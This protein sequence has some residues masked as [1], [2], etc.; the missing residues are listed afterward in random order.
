M[1]IREYGWR[2]CLLYTVQH[3]HHQPEDSLDPRS[4]GKGPGPGLMLHLHER[5]CIIIE[6]WMHAVA[7][8]EPET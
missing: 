5:E 1:T 2:S 4:Q 3:R 8:F 7:E 6:N